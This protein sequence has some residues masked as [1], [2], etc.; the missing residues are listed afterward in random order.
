MQVL[1]AR[2]KLREQLCEHSG[3]ALGQVSED[4]PTVRRADAMAIVAL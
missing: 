3:F 4:R 1:A 2:R